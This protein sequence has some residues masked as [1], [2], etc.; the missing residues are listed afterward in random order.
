MT[1]TGRQPMSFGKAAQPKPQRWGDHAP[2]HKRGRRA[3]EAAR[4]ESTA[5]EGKEMAAAGGG[6]PGVQRR[7]PKQTRRQKM[8]RAAPDPAPS[9]GGSPGP[10][11]PRRP[12]PSTTAKG[13]GGDVNEVWRREQRRRRHRRRRKWGQPDQRRKSCRPRQIRKGE[14]GSARWGR[15]SRAKWGEPASEK[16]GVA[17]VPS[18]RR[19]TPREKPR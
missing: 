2:A 12:T 10:T 15:R 16:K 11:R 13:K 4:A 17:A 18:G 9:R 5:E 8:G 19:G 6:Q 1:T 7:W 14:A 3:V